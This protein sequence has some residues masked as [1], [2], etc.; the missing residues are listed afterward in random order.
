MYDSTKK[1]L[2][3]QTRIDFIIVSNN[4]NNSS[5]LNSTNLQK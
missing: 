4:V 2:D 1:V 5:K 3:T